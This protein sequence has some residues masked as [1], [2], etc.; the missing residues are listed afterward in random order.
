[1]LCA[2]HT[3]ERCKPPH[4]HAHPGSSPACRPSCTARTIPPRGRRGSP[5]PPSCAGATRPRLRGRA[6][7]HL[8]V[9]IARSEWLALMPSQWGTAQRQSHACCCTCMR[10]PTARRGPSQRSAWRL[11]GQRFNQSAALTPIHLLLALHTHA[12]RAVPHRSRHHGLQNTR[13]ACWRRLGWLCPGCPLRRPGPE[14]QQ[15][16][17]CRS[18]MPAAEASFPPASPPRFQGGPAAAPPPSRR[19]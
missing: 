18:C 7:A 12:L 3:G 14:Q 8:C 17:P 15:Q 16:Q 6:P 19:R 5:P 13:T 2:A 10:L 4:A 9:C 11:S 1:M